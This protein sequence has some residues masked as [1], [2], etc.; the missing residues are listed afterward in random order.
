MLIQNSNFYIDINAVSSIV[1]DHKHEFV[2]SAYGDETKEF[3][4]LQDGIDQHIATAVGFPISIANE[5]GRFRKPH[6]YLHYEINATNNNQLVLVVAIENT[7]FSIYE[8]FSGIRSTSQLENLSEFMNKET[9]PDDWSMV[10]RINLQ[11]NDFL[12]FSPD[13]WHSFEENTIQ[14]FYINKL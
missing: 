6:E 11:P 9:S 13:L 4:Y 5:S 14:V 2:Y 3:S 12:V 7:Y 8:H 10:T 1:S